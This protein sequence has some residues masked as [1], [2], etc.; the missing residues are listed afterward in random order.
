MDGYADM[1]ALNK[2]SSKIATFAVRM[3]GAKIGEYTFTSKRDSRPVVQHKFEAWLVGMNAQAYCLGYVKGSPATVKQAQDKFAEGSVWALSKVVFDT[4]TAMT[5]IS[6]PVPFRLDV[7]KSKMEPIKND[8]LCKQMPQEPVP[9]RSVADIARITSKRSTDL[10]AVVKDVGEQRT[11]KSGL[12]VADV[13][14]IDNSE[15]S[16]GVLATIKVG[17]FGHEKVE[18]LRQHVGEPMVFFNLSINFADGHL[19]I[20]HFPGD[21]IQPAP[22]CQKTEALGNQKNTLTLATNT[23]TLTAEWTPQQSRDASGPVPLSCAAFLDFTAESPEAK[24]P[25]VVQVMWVH[26]EE[27]EPDAQVKDPSGERL[28]FRTPLR[29]A[30]GATTVGVP[31]KVALKVSNCQS[32][33]FFLDRHTN[34]DLNLPL[35]CHVRITRTYKE[36]SGGA[37]QPTKYVNHTVASVEPIDW[38]PSA[39]P[40][41]AYKDILSVLNLCPPHEEGIAFAFL[42]DIC[43]DPYYGFSINYDGKPGPLCRYVIALLSSEKKSDTK[44]VGDGFKVTTTD[45]KDV[46]Q[47]DAP[48]APQPGCHTVVGYCSLNDLAGFRLDPPRGKAARC[49]LALFSKK[50]DEGFHI[51]K[52]EYVEPDHVQSAI[53]CI[54]KLRTLCKQVRPETHDKRSHAVAMADSWAATEGIKKARVLQQVPTDASLPD[55]CAEPDVESFLAGS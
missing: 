41:A 49:A 26:L 23:S 13:T 12:V 30:S 17:V 32:L 51:H 54:R 9:P 48:G 35:L 38:S 55:G 39:A 5:F 8:D 46:A 43:P 22:V 24:M 2:S 20:S 19:S 7:G 11:T 36:V 21:L 1:A 44:I 45:V 37:S 4:Y 50:D 29:D 33:Q 40:N 53:H 47:P 31:Q 52:Q 27:P 18:V 16:A 28:W 42:G 25:E 34:G 10:I 15:T 3:V 14:L 6:T